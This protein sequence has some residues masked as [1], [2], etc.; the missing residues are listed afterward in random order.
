[1]LALLGRPASQ[2][3]LAESLAESL[4]ETSPDGPS[5]EAPHLLGC[6][7]IQR[8]AEGSEAYFGMFAVRPHLQGRGVGRAVIGEA[9]RLAGEWGCTTLRMT[10]IRQRVELIDWYRRLGFEPTG[11]TEPFPY[12]D[13]RFGLPRRDDLE[14]VVLAGPTDLP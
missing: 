7:H 10:V 14:F 11:A 8:S 12:G 2:V 3:V 5:E 6:C 9:R 1:V 4:A 13:E